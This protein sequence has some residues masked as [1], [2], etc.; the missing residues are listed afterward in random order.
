MCESQPCSERLANS[1]LQGRIFF[2]SDTI[3]PRLLQYT[4]TI[5]KIVKLICV[6]LSVWLI[7]FGVLT[8]T[9]NA[10]SEFDVNPPVIELDEMREGIAGET[11]VFIARATDDLGLQDVKLYHRFAGQTPYGSLLMTEIADSGYFSAN[12]P[13]NDTETR[14]IEYY[15]QARDNGGNRVI[16]GFAFEPYLRNLATPE[17]PISPDNEIIAEDPET[18]PG[19]DPGIDPGTNQEASPQS[20][21]ESKSGGF[22]WWYVVVAIIVAGGIAAAA[23]GSDSGNSNGS[24]NPTLVPGTVTIDV[25]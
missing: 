11:Q 16:K 9:A 21:A 15:I 4:W 2:R 6:A 7:C 8:S 14:T 17:A 20:T 19:I 13:T 18:D 10:Q 22:K 25:L 5:M 23:G 1:D 24:E 3:A 12:V